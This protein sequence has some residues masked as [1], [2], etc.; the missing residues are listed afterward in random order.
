MAALVLKNAFNRE[1][2]H[3]SPYP[4]L[5]YSRNLTL[6]QSSVTDWVDILTADSVADEAYDGSVSPAWAP[7]IHPN[8]S[9]EFPSSSTR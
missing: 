6:Q 4:F 9:P 7:S 2:P 8:C 1:K 3:V 5:S